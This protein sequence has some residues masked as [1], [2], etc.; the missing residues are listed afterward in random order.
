MNF[1]DNLKYLLIQTKY[2]VYTLNKIKQIAPYLS[3][4]TDIVL[5]TDTYIIC[6]KDFWTKDNLTFEILNNYIHYSEQINSKIISGS[7]KTYIFVLIV[8]NF[9]PDF[10]N[11]IYNK[12]NIHIIKK[13]NKNKLIKEISYFLYSCN[14]FLY[15]PDNSVIMLE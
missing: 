1:I 2:N 4:C 11:G 6:F 3:V 9:K 14:I 8:K 15:E 12:K 5:E 7:G 10:D 13:F